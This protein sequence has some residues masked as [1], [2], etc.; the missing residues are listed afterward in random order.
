M[1]TRTSSTIIL[2]VA[3]SGSRFY[4]T[5]S[6]KAGTCLLAWGTHALYDVKKMHSLKCPTVGILWLVQNYHEVWLSFR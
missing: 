6:L 4:E 5:A 3:G 1:G 2:T